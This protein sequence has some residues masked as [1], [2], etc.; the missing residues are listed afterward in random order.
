MKKYLLVY[1]PNTSSEHIVY[2]ISDL[3]HKQI[4]YCSSD[5]INEID[6]SLYHRIIFCF[7]K[8]LRM[9]KKLNNKPLNDDKYIFFT[10]EKDGVFPFKTAS[11]GWTEYVTGSQKYYIPLAS[12]IY[13]NKPQNLKTEKAI[14]FYVNKQIYDE[15]EKQKVRDI[16]K[17]MDC[18]TFELGVD[19]T[20][21]YEFFNAITH[22]YYYVPKQLDTLPCVLLEAMTSGVNICLNGEPK[23]GSL[24]LWEAYCNDNI[25][26]DVFT[27]IWQKLIDAEFEYEIDKE[28]YSSFNEWIEKEIL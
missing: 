1:E 9:W 20:D 12:L 18:K 10:K 11:M 19:F 4:D 13:F 23:G 25:T 17:T 8:E 3:F 26:F 24:D 5:E 7:R 6:H 16:M 2:P 27:K 28:K 15:Y 22:F 14:G 21:K